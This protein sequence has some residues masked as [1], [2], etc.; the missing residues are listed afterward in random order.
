MDDRWQIF[1]DGPRRWVLVD[2]WTDDPAPAYETEEA[3]QA[4]KRDLE[5]QPMP[6]HPSST[7]P[8]TEPTARW[9]NIMAGL[10]RSGS[11]IAREEREKI[12]AALSRL[13][14]VE[15]ERDASDAARKEAERLLDMERGDHEESYHLWS[16]SCAMNGACGQTVANERHKRSR[17]QRGTT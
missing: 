16:K 1:N 11:F 4:V 9:L 15:Q 14:Q 6:D 7:P 10:I 2:N 12:A 17:Q 8:V 3:A 13:D 5:D